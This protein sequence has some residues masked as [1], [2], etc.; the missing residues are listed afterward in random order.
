VLLE[1]S[2]DLP[3]NHEVARPKILY[4]EL[5][6]SYAMWFKRK[7]YQATGNDVRVGV[8]VSDSLVGPFRHLTGFFLGDPQD[9][10]ADFCLWQEP[11]GEAFIVASSPSLL[12]GDYARRILMFRLA[13]DYRSAEP[14]PVYVGSA[15]G[16]EAPAVFKRHDTYYLVT[17]GTSG[18]EANQSM[19]RTAPSILG[20][21]RS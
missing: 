17:S 19:Y 8:A 3:A 10:T 7:Y 16:R 13:P 18:W 9:N 4:N 20:P 21:G 6:S 11:D 1:P 15:D 5:T 2:G 14:Q 12:G